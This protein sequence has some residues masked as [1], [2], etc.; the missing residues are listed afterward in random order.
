MRR[1]A[2]EIGR[3]RRTARLRARGLAARF[4]VLALVACTAVGVAFAQNA[5]NGKAL[6]R[7]ECQVCHSPDPSTAVAPFNLIMT[8]ANNPA[9]ITAASVN[10]PSQM[11]FINDVSTASDLADLAAYIATFSAN[12]PTVQ[13]IEYYAP[14]QD[15]YF[16]TWMAGE[17]AALDTG[18]IKGWQ[19]TGFSFAAYATAQAGTSDICRFYIPP[20]DGDSHFYGRGAAECAAT[21]SAHPEFVLEDPKFMAMFL[22]IAGVCPAGTTEVYRVF[23]NRVDA[24]HRYMTDPS[25]RAQMVARGWVAEGDGPNLVVMCAPR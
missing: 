25:V 16:I 2:A 21:G 9:A 7:A 4:T 19:R 3:G 8:A 22:P 13:V 5:T 1:P 10:Y 11:G 15:H 18:Q 17:I 24:N 14:G 20:A 6:Y 23:D 12:P